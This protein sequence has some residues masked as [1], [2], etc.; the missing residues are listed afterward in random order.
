MHSLTNESN[1][2]NKMICLIDQF[3]FIQ[4]SD[5]FFIKKAT[6]FSSKKRRS[7]HSKKRR[8]LHSKKRRFFHQKTTMF[9]FKKATI[10]SSKKRRSSHF[11]KR[12][13]SYSKKRRFSYSKKR[14]FS[15]SKKRRFLLKRYVLEKYSSKSIDDKR[16]ISIKFNL[17]YWS[18]YWLFDV[19]QLTSIEIYLYSTIYE[20][21]C[22]D[23][24]LESYLSRFH[25]VEWISRDETLRESFSRTFVL[26]YLAYFMIRSLRIWATNSIDWEFTKTVKQACLIRKKRCND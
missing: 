20:M 8:F 4:K 14:R 12:R 23:V 17:I 15:H 9:S 13:F 5:D 6:I 10:S 11:K 16:L 26:R 3:V 19:L 2:S 21:N 24:E 1:L 7:F 22:F 18:E 25:V